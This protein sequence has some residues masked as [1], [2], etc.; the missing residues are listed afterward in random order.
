MTASL[1]Q[2]W[3]HPIKAHGR[4]ELQEVTLTAG[5]TLPYDRH[6]AVAH[7][8][9]RLEGDGWHPCRN[10]SRGASAPGLMAMTCALDEP[11]GQITARHPDLGEITFDPETEGAAFVAW[12]QPL[13][14]ATRSA[15]ARLIRANG[16]GLTDSDFPSIS[17]INM[18]S[19]RAVGQWLGRDLSPQR[20]RGNFLIDGLAPWEEFDLVGKSLRIGGAVLEVREPITRCL[21]TTAN[22]E[23]GKRDAATLKALNDGWRHQEFGVYAVVTEGGSI[24]AGDPVE[25]L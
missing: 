5:R 2:I 10:F 18:A 4:E 11:T 22:P 24:A 23:T 16:I 7:E 21:A 6:W 20:W 8:D 15:S 3:R 25:V 1:A 12:S 17:L 19:H 13:I 14:P 9:A